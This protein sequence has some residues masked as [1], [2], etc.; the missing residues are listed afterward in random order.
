VTDRLTDRQTEER[1]LEG[2]LGV[3]MAGVLV[4]VPRLRV[5]AI[6]QPVPGHPVLLARVSATLRHYAGDQ[7]RWTDVEL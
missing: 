4:V 7:R 6:R 5:V 2:D 3:E 1:E